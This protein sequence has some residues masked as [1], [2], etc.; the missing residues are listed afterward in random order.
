MFFIYKLIKF[1]LIVDQADRTL[2]RRA[3]AVEKKS[4]DPRYYP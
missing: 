2:K 4:D 1:L 3:K